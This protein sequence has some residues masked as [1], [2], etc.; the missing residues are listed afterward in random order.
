MASQN[1]VTRPGSQFVQSGTGAVERTVENKLKDVVSVKDFGAVGDGVTDDTAAIQAALDVGGPI[2]FPAGSYKITDTLFVTKSSTT[3][4]GAGRGAS[5]IAAGT[6]FTGSGEL[7]VKTMIQFNR[8]PHT[9]KLFRCGLENITVTSAKDGLQNPAV[10]CLVHANWIHHFLAT[11]AVF[12]GAYGNGSNGTGLILTTKSNSGP[13]W[14]MFNTVVD[15]DFT[16]CVNGILWGAAGHGDVNAGQVYRTRF[17]GGGY[18]GVGIKVESGSYA[19]SFVDNDIE[20]FSTAFSL[21]NQPNFLRGNLAEQNTTDFTASGVVG[22]VLSGNEL[23]I[24]SSEAP[25]V[26]LNEHGSARYLFTASPMP[27]LIVDGKFNSK[28]YE[29]AFLGTTLATSGADETGKYVLEM[30][31]GVSVT[32]RARLMVNTSGANLNGWYT[33]VV[34]AKSTAASGTGLYIKL[35]GGSH[36]A[37]RFSEIKTGTTDYLELLEAN[38]HKFV[39]NIGRT[40]SLKSDYRTYFGSVYLTNAN[41]RA[42]TL[43]LA[44]QGSGHTITVD[45]V[46]LFEGFNAGIPSDNMTWETYLDVSDL[47]TGQSRNIVQLPYPTQVNSRITSLL[48]GSV[49]RSINQ[50]PF[51]ARNG[52][53]ASRV[54]WRDLNTFGYDS[55][56]STNTYDHIYGPNNSLLQYFSRSTLAGTD[57]LYFRID[58]Y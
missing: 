46:G 28:L 7:V 10:E 8:F 36:S 22:P 56:G 44:V 55:V 11:K 45:Y 33:F 48:T 29:S 17:G 34:R 47:T 52:V 39:A 40:G 51:L 2:L 49:S 30:P 25:G 21:N 18:G 4:I 1:F 38:S 32:D 15:S 42:N 27:S 58:F 41:V 13:E 31:G 19:N 5:S 53:A 50:S 54:Y 20:S 37:Y 16:Y 14:S 12:Y 35:P 24:V 3:L 23:N 6:D 26:H 9:E 43:Y 57:P